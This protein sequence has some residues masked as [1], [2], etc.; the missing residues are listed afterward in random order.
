MNMVMNL[1]RHKIGDFLGHKS[2][3]YDFKD[4]TAWR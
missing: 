4:P 3:D 2:E 1:R